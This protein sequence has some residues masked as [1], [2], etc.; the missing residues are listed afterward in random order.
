[1]TLHEA[2]LDGLKRAADHGL[3]KPEDV[4]M[5]IQVSIDDAGL[6]VVRKPGSGNFDNAKKS[7]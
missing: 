1:M 7:W 6:R 2:I 5:A 3:T 4:S